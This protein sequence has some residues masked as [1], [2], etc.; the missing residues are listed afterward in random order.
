MHIFLN[1]VHPINKISTLYNIYFQNIE[2]FVVAS[3]F[4][5][6][7]KKSLKKMYYRI[8]ISIQPSLIRLNCIK[9][10]VVFHNGQF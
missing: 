1:F 10:P 6:K 2:I 9:Y 5:A 7:S 8:H 3:Q 4:F